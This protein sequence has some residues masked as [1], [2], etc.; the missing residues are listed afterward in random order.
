MIDLDGEEFDQF[1]SASALKTTLE[2]HCPTLVCIGEFDPLTSIAEGRALYRNHLKGPTEFLV[3]EDA[4]YGSDGLECLRGM[5]GTD[6]AADWVM[7][8]ILGKPVNEGEFLVGKNSLGPYQPIQLT[9]WQ[10]MYE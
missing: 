5:S 3:F 6:L 4:F 8:R 7:D 10:T 9:T 2:V 1:V